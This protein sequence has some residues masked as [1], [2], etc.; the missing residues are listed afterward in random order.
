MK[1]LSDILVDLCNLGTLIYFEES[2][3][4]NL[5]IA[6]V[7]WLNMVFKQVISLKTTAEKRYVVEMKRNLVF[8]SMKQIQKLDEDWIWEIV[9]LTLCVLCQ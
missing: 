1:R 3:L 2:T 4:S 6:D 7:K 5:V 8:D 9:H